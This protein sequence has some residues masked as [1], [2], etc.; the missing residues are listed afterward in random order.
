MGA[1]MGIDQQA[2]MAMP[3]GVFMDL[4]A[5]DAISKGTAKEKT[6]ARPMDFDDFLALR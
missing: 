4:M 2:V 1:Q 6:K 3:Y 5:C